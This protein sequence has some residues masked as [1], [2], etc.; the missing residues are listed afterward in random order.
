[1]WVTNDLLVPKDVLL[2]LQQLFQKSYRSPIRF[3][4]IRVPNNIRPQKKVLRC[5]RSVT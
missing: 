3:C 4:A 1:M 2:N 5:M